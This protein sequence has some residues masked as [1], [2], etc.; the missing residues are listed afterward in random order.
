D[1][2]GW[3][4]A[5]P[6]PI[7]RRIRGIETIRLLSRAGV[8]VVCAGGGGIPIIVTAAGTIEGVEAVV[9]KDLTAALL[10][11]AVDAD[12]LLILTDVPAVWTRWPMNEGTPIRRATTRELRALTFAAGSM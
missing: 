1:G 11:E 10:A 3:R 6:S 12:I 8:V 2:D 4:R 5:V 7:P 9:D